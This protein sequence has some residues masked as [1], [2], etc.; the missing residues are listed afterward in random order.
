MYKRQAWNSG[1]SSVIVV[2]NLYCTLVLNVRNL[3][4]FTW[5]TWNW[6]NWI[7]WL[8]SFWV[9]AWN[10]WFCTWSSL[11]WVSW[12]VREWCRW[13]TW[14]WVSVWIN[15]NNITN[16]LVSYR[17]F[18]VVL[19]YGSC[20]YVCLVCV[21]TFYNWR[22][23]LVISSFLTI[24]NCPVSS[25]L[26]IWNNFVSYSINSNCPRPLRVLN[27]ISWS[28]VVRTNVVNSFLN[29]LG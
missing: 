18:N 5:V 4:I 16:R 2:D 29:V 1:V 22:I 7:A 6:V 27:T 13:Y 20:W 21:V 17:L 28:L 26:T 9:V 10:S 8:T 19:G 24:R 12:V 23:Y 15:W 25:V 11:S 3:Y 14:N